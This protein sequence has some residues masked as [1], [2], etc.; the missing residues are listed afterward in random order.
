MAF[1]CDITSHLNALNLQLQ[2]RGCVITDMYAAV[3]AFKTKLRLWETQMQQENLSHFPCCQTMKEQVSTAVF[4]RAKFAEKLS[5]LGADFTQRFA[6]FEAQKSRF[7]LLS[8]PFAAD[9][10]SA[11]TNIQ[12]ELIELQCSDTLKAKY[13]SV[14][15]AQFLRF[16]PDTMPQL[17][18]LFTKIT[19]M[20]N[21][22]KVEIIKRSKRGETPSVTGKALGYSWSTTGTILKDK[23]PAKPGYSASLLELTDRKEMAMDKACEVAFQRQRKG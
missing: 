17:L 10:E 3:R 7:E 14:G 2:G 19:M 20:T 21:E 15:A 23:V 12:M 1:L 6:D 5:I 8:N 18:F 13:D 16:I 22:N 4:P 9:V 11:P